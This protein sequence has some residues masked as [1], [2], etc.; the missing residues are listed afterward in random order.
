[1]IQAMVPLML[2][3]SMMQMFTGAFRMR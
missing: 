1:M 2:I 3:M